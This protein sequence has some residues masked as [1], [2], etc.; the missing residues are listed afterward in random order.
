MKKVIKL[1]LIVML[2]IIVC[3][4][5]N[6]YAL[7]CNVNLGTS[8]TE[9]STDEE[10]V[11]NV[12]ISNIKSDKGVISF[13]GLLEYDKDSLTLVKMEGKNGW[14]TP[15]EAATYNSANGKIAITRSGLGKS[16]E[17][18]IAITFKV[19][20]TSAPTVK[21]ALKDVTV[22]DSDLADIGTIEKTI[23][24]VEADG[25]SG[26]DEDSNNSQG[27]TTSGTK[28]NTSSSKKQP[29][30]LPKTGAEMNTIFMVAGGT[31]VV[32]AGIFYIRMRKLNK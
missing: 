19:K 21:I 18:M 6:V 16:N 10:I 17:T 13:G 24:I 23:T 2:G 12:N 11:V 15:T 27:S 29:T 5:S 30:K 28:N 7:S 20:P 32:L 1:S 31:S 4:T 26:S 9:Y 25:S 3:M 22:S 8:K 14:E